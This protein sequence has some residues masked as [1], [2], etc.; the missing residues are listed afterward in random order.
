[1]SRPIT[2]RAL[3]ALMRHQGWIPTNTGWDDP[4]GA[5]SV[6]FSDGIALVT[7]HNPRDAMGTDETVAGARTMHELSLALA[8]VPEEIPAGKGACDHP[9]AE[10]P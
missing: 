4:R 10:I 2:K 1:M 6:R 7:Y 5:A 9:F 8:M 3:D